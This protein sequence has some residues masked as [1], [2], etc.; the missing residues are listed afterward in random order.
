MANFFQ[1]LF[2]GSDNGQPREY[3][4]DQDSAKTFGDIDYMRTPKKVKKSF[5][6]PGKSDEIV[7]IEEIVS[8]TEKQE[9]EVEE[10]K[11]TNSNSEIKAPTFQPKPGE[12]KSSGDMDIFRNLAKDIRRR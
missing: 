6:V 8:A 1:R 12:A 11:Q 10:R 2:G 3:F 7:E 9:Y 4:L 5:P